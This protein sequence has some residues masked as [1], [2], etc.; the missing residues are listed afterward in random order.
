MFRIV[1]IL[2]ICI[3]AVSAPAQEVEVVTDSVKNSPD[4]LVIRKGG[5]IITIESYAKR[6]QPR[7]ALL[8]AAILPGMGQ[9]YNKKYWKLPIVYGGFFVLTSVAVT[10]NR[11][12]DK[13]KN[14]LFLVL[15]TPGST[16]PDGFSE[17]QLR[18]ITDTYRRQR[19]YF[20]ILNSFRCAS[21]WA[22]TI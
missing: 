18:S 16:S 8:Y 9:V 19:D 5:K 11:L 17:T 13:Y 4:S 20:L 12:H 3:V 6:F 15:S 2:V 10:Y 7:K 21:T 22:S 14:E 1:L